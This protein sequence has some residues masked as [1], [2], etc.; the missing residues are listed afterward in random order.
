MDADLKELQK[1]AGIVH[2]GLEAARAHLEE[3]F[4]ALV[5]SSSRNGYSKAI[6][7]LLKLV[8]VDR[9]QQYIAQKSDADEGY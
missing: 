7:T 1:R 9:L 2:E 3:Q 6:D 8:P 5:D 4:W